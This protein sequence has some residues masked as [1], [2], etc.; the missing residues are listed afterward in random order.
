[1]QIIEQQVEVSDSVWHWEPSPDVW[2]DRGGLDP[3]P[4]QCFC[5]TCGGAMPCRGCHTKSTTNQKES[6]HV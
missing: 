1:M 2:W 5:L 4:E 3:E 6:T